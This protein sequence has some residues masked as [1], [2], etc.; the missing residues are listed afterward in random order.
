MVA[1]EVGVEDLVAVVVVVVVVVVVAV[2]I[3]ILSPLVL[4]EY[5]R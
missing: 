3:S 1:A 5:P 4:H 2:V